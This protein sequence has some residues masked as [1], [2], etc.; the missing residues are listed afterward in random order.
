[1]CA[2]QVLSLDPERRCV[3]VEKSECLGGVEDLEKD[4]LPRLDEESSHQIEGG[5]V[6]DLLVSAVPELAPSQ[7]EGREEAEVEDVLERVRL[8]VGALPY[9]HEDELVA[10]PGDV[11]GGVEGVPNV[12]AGGPVVVVLAAVVLVEGVSLEALARLEGDDL[13]PRVVEVHVE[14]EELDEE[15]AEVGPLNRDALVVL[16]LELQ[17]GDDHEDE[18]V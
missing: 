4:V 1:M 18:T 8:C 15:L 2:S 6:P 14:V 10:G 11:V 12:H 5:L 16:E 3:F 9:S 13:H 17:E 7:R